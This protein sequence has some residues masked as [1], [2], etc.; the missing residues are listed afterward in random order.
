MELHGRVRADGQCDISSKGSYFLSF[1]NGYVLHGRKKKTM[2]PS[3]AETLKGT[4]HFLL[5]KASN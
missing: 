1:L 3:L 2:V 4:V 5:L